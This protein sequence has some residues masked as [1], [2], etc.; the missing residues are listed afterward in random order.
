ML[1]ATALAVEGT[2]QLLTLMTGKLR[3]VLA[4]RAGPPM[5]PRVSMM[6]QGVYGKKL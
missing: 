2:P 5:G 1:N 3:M 4:E 6:W